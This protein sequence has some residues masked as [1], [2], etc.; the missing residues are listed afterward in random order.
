MKIILQGLTSS[1]LVT[2][3]YHAAQWVAPSYTYP[4][5]GT[6][7]SRRLRAERIEGRLVARRS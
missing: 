1:R 3:G 4:L 5:E 6:Q 2:Q 7:N